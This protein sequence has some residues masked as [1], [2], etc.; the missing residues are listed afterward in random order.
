MPKPQ[1][2]HRSKESDM[3]LREARKSCGLTQAQ[4]A[5]ELEVDTKTVS[6]WENG[7]CTPQPYAQRKLCS[8]YGKS[9]EEL[10]F[11]VSKRAGQIQEDHTTILE[12]EEPVLVGETSGVSLQDTETVFLSN[13][14]SSGLSPTSS[15]VQDGGMVSAQKIPS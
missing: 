2:M 14:S 8:L 11:T 1:V 3:A 6:R 13:S 9:P 15:L 4:V 7:E 12:E 10:G 5:A